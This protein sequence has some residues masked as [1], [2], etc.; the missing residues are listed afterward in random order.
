MHTQHTGY[1]T[2]QVHLLT[3]RHLKM[4]LCT[5]RNVW[6][7]L[8]SKSVEGILV[9]QNRVAQP[10]VR[11]RGRKQQKQDD[12]TACMQDEYTALRTCMQAVSAFPSIL[13]CAGCFAICMQTVSSFTC[14]LLCARC[15]G[16][17]MQADPLLSRREMRDCCF[18]HTQSM[19][20][21]MVPVNPGSACWY[22]W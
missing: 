9:R 18:V 20:T 15:F 10:V 17:C 16:I 14:I 19:G 21:V 1:G 6:C 5:P 22:S 11:A 12:F 7:T 13:V 8:V 4:C 3:F 2:C